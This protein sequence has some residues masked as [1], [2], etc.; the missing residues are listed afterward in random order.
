MKCYSPP[1]LPPDPCA[2]S[3]GGE[4]MEQDGGLMNA[5]CCLPRLILFVQ[6]ASPPP[7]PNTAVRT[8]QSVGEVFKVSMRVCVGARY[9]EKKK[10]ARAEPL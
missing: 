4:E 10:N 3:R 2:G 8:L 5:H 6:T 7:T 9:M 1:P